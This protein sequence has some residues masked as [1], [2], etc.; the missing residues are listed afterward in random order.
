MRRQ[1]LFQ[2]AYNGGK[3]K[4]N[5]LNRLVD[6]SKST[7]VAGM[8]QGQDLNSDPGVC[9]WSPALYLGVG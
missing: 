7:Y 9:P 2:T 1:S 6:V 5:L 3:K 8:G 4:K